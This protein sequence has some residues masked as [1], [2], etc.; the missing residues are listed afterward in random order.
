MKDGGLLIDAQSQAVLTAHALPARRDLHADPVFRLAQHRHA[1]HAHS[2]DGL[3]RSEPRRKNLLNAR[4][5]GPVLNGQFRPAGNLAG[6][7][8]RGLSHGASSAGY[9]DQCGSARLMATVY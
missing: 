9:R 7:A 3:A 8:H 6:P 1:V 2:D 5:I 4:R